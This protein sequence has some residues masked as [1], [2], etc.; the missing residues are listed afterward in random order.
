M[1]YPYHIQSLAPSFGRK[2]ITL[3]GSCPANTPLPYTLHTEIELRDNPIND[4]HRIIV[5]GWKIKHIDPLDLSKSYNDNL[6]DLLH[7][8]CDL[9]GKWIDS[10][11]IGSTSII[12]S[13]LRRTNPDA[14]IRFIFRSH[15]KKT[16]R[17]YI[18][19]WETN[20][21]KVTSIVNEVLEIFYP[22]AKNLETR[23]F[24]VSIG[25]AF[26]ASPVTVPL[27]IFHDLV[28][29]E[30]TPI[31]IPRYMSSGPDDT[32]NVNFRPLQKDPTRKVIKETFKTEKGTFNVQR[33]ATEKEQRQGA[34]KAKREKLVDKVARQDKALDQLQNELQTLQKAYKALLNSNDVATRKRDRE[35]ESLQQKNEKLKRSKDFAIEKKNE[36]IDE[37]QKIADQMLAH[38]N[39]EKL[40]LEDD[41]KNFGKRLQNADWQIQNLQ[42]QV[43]SLRQRQ[44]HSGIIMQPEKESE[45]FVGEFEIALMSAIHFAMENSPVKANSCKLRS[46]DIWKAFISANTDAE[47]RYR[48]YKQDVSQLLNASRKNNFLRS[49]DMLNKFGI[50]CDHHTNNHIKIRFCDDDPRYSST[51]ASTLSDN[52]CGAKNFA[53]DLKNAF[54]YY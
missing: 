40:L 41:N 24:S 16:A 12:T 26:C 5:Y 38:N 19:L 6:L 25:E 3:C 50:K 1:N 42:A 11:N 46:Q 36:E 53:E 48:A 32:W 20:P 14:N 4:M 29:R 31:H 45:K 18:T 10:T 13:E 34:K 8:G 49:A 28:I 47:S 22:F 54:F 37:I 9:T 2:Y 23:L 35:I 7:S 44:E 52:A 27:K 17:L 21:D 30:T 33:Y 43:Q 39:Q 51:H 15:N